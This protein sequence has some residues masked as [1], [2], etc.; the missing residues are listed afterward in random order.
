MGNGE[1]G[2]EDLGVVDRRIVEHVD[3]NKGLKRLGGW[4]GRCRPV[5]YKVT[6]S[7]RSARDGSEHLSLGICVLL[8]KIRGGL[9]HGVQVF[10][11]IVD[12]TTL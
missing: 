4:V 9:E 7:C 6:Y 2:H 11:V 12:D 3:S 8:L 5:R 1:E 10:S